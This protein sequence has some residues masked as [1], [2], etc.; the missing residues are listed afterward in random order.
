MSASQTTVVIPALNDARNLARLV[1][2]LI[3]AGHQVVVVDGGSLDA[4]VDVARSAG[5]TVIGA[6]GAS[7]EQ[8]VIFGTSHATGRVMVLPA[9]AVPALDLAA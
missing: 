1:P 5:A 6:V 9:D 7:R 8:A 3:A 2:L 4:S